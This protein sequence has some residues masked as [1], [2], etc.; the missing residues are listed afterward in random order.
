MQ[1]TRGIGGMFYSGEY[2]LFVNSL[3]FIRWVSEAAVCRCFSR[4]VPK[5]FA[6]FIKKIPVLESL[7][8]NVPILEVCNF[9]IKRLQH[10][11][12]PVSIAKF[13]NNSLVRGF[14]WKRG[15]TLIPI[16]LWGVS[17]ILYL[18]GRLLGWFYRFSMLICYPYSI[19]LEQLQWLLLK[20][21]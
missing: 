1:G 18:R 2:R 6:I 5:N 16:T 9:T 12:F 4:H 21:L 10:I 17:T 11:C 15:S 8:N 19:F 7:S 14:P 20:F 13:F 3:V